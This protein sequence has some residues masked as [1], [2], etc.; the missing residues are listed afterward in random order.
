MS[1]QNGTRRSYGTGSLFF[2]TD[3]AGRETW[4][5]MWRV[6]GRQIK[7][8]VGPKRTEGNRDGL[9]RAQ[10]ETELRRLMSEKVT[11]AHRAAEARSLKD[12]GDR[13]LKHLE[14]AGRKKATRV[15]VESALRVHLLPFFDGKSV[16]RIKHEDVVDLVAVLEERDLSGKSIHNYVGTLSA[17]LN[18]AMLPPR[19]WVGANPCVG[20]E[21]PAIEQSSEIRFLDLDE[22]DALVNAAVE[23]PY[24]ALD[25][26]FYRVAAMTG[27]RHG[28][29]IA[30]RWRDVDWTIAKIRVRQNWVL[31]EYDTPKSKRGSRSVPMAPEVGGALD[32]LFKAS[33]DPADDDLVFPDPVTGEP[34]SKAAN[35][36]RFRKAL[37]AAGLDTTRIIHDLR[38]TFGTRMA[39]ANIS[40]RTL[41]EYMGHR[42]LATTQIYADYAPSAREAEFVAAAFARGNERGNDLSESHMIGDA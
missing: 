37:K 38:H 16:D 15:A 17:I 4:Y 34:L 33:G 40:M 26:T 3:K 10:A 24:Q 1:K 32:R 42:D 20:V 12:V 31:D 27:L 18:W 23:G 9:T 11:P 36:R 19:K 13:Y 39:A 30:L 6:N 5:G 2:R 28:E 7:R 22:L 14:R 35:L 25:R 8:K 29:M 41:Q 21:L